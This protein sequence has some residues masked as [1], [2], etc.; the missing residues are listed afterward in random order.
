[1][2]C[3]T[4]LQLFHVLIQEYQLILG[5]ILHELKLIRLASPVGHKQIVSPELCFCLELNPP[6]M[7]LRVSQRTHL[8]LFPETILIQ[9]NSQVD[10]F[11]KTHIASR[12][13]A[14]R[15][16]GETLPIKLKSCD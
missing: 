7:T 8:F 4:Y 12:S 11:T 15:L 3:R 1:M 9:R 2:H 10:A 5:A 6:L 14:H 13:H 16:R